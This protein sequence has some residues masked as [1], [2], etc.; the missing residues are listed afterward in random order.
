MPDVE[1]QLQGIEQVGLMDDFFDAWFPLRALDV[2]GEAV[3]G[4]TVDRLDNEETAPDGSSWEQWAESTA[5]ARSG[6][7]KLLRQSGDLRDSIEFR[8]RGGEVLEVGSGL[9]YAL[10]HQDGSRDGRIPARP[11]VGISSTLEA[12]LDEI[13]SADFDR[14]WQAVRR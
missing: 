12:A 1:F 5:R 9:D 7:D 8:V 10:V 2:T 11:Y 4:D 13:Y 6:D 14:G 3:V